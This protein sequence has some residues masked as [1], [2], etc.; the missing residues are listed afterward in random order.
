MYAPF[1]A[2]YIVLENTGPNCVLRINCD[3]QSSWEHDSWFWWLG[4][5]VLITTNPEVNV[6]TGAFKERGPADE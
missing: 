6:P 4:R 3:A 1:L 2:I 5:P